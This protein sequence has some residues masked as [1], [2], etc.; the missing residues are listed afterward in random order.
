MKRCWTW[1]TIF[2]TFQLHF[3]DVH[4]QWV[5]AWMQLN[6]PLWSI[7]GWLLSERGNFNWDQVVV[8]V[9]TRNDSN[10]KF[11]SVKSVVDR[12]H[13]PS[14]HNEIV[15]NFELMD[16]GSNKIQS[17]F[18]L[19]MTPRTSIDD[20]S[21]GECTLLRFWALSSERRMAYVFIQFRDT[22]DLI[23]MRCMHINRITSPPYAVHP[24]Y[25]ADSVVDTQRTTTEIIIFWF[26]TKDS[27]KFVF[28]YRQRHAHLFHSTQKSWRR[29]HSLF[30]CAFFASFS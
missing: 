3:I 1:K 8:C 11:A 2:F 7:A 10:F 4:C 17:P 29:W 26:K 13:S 24:T 14:P 28:I 19:N 25:T 27:G 15:I 6:W 20:N 23:C 22:N 12:S 5:W 18:V 30:D 9:T 21:N 16:V